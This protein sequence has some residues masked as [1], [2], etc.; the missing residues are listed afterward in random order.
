MLSPFTGP[1]SAIITQLPF[2]V[3]G[4]DCGIVRIVCYFVTKDSF[5]TSGFS[6]LISWLQTMAKYVG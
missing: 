1:C 2:F 6:F 4:P 3:M 5:H